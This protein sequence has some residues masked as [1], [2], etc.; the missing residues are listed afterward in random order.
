MCGKAYGRLW[1]VRNLKRLG[2]VRSELV[3]VYT[4]QCRS[5][6]ELAVPVWSAGLTSDDILSLERVQKTAC[7]IILGRAY[8]GYDDALEQLGLGTLES[9]RIDLCRKFARKASENEIYQHWFVESDAKAQ[10][11]KTRSKKM[12]NKYKDIKFRTDRFRD[13]PLPY[14]TSLLN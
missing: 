14:L 7:A 11:I 2:A 8:K 5:I 9:R 4:K 13:S 6:L 1:I 12:A 3:D 10:E